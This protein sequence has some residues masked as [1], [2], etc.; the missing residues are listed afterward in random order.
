MSIPTGPEDKEFWKEHHNQYVRL[1]KK[2][3]AEGK[4]H[5]AAWYKERI[6]GY[7]KLMGLDKEEK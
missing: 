7:R 4:K 1:Y 5:T 2:A 6:K 3:K